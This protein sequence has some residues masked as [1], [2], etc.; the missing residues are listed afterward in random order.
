MDD[1]IDVSLEMDGREL[2]CL[3]FKNISL[4]E[5][6]AVFKREFPSAETDS[7]ETNGV[8]VSLFQIEDYSAAL[9][10][11]DGLLYELYIF[12][13]SDIFRAGDVV[14]AFLSDAAL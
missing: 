13:E 6:Q 11:K 1:Y 9:W 10:E 2:D 14:E 7:F 12:D 8:N 4:K 3:I 5:E